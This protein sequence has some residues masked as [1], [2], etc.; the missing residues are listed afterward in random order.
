MD[1]CEA[2]RDFGADRESSIT[3]MGIAHDKN[4]VWIHVSEKQKLLNEVFYQGIHVNVIKSVPGIVGRAQ[5]QI[6]VTALFRMILV[7]ALHLLPLAVVEFFGCTT[8]P[9]HRDEEWPTVRRASTYGFHRVGAQMFIE[10][11]LLALEIR[12]G[13]VVNGRGAV[14]TPYLLT[15]SRFVL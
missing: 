6:K 11:H 10:P 7:I 8:A 14:G 3:A 9:V 13:G 1:G 15:D 12:F 2:V 4:L 5:C